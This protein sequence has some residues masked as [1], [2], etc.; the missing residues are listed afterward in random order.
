MNRKLVEC[1]ERLKQ[2]HIF[3]V[4]A[5]AWSPAETRLCIEGKQARATDDKGHISAQPVTRD[6]LIEVARSWTSLGAR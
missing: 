6:Q 5:L 1:K 2:R 3:E 4:W